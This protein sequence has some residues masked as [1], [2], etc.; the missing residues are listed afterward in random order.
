MK[1]L[2][3]FLMVGLAFTVLQ[4]AGVEAQEQFVDPDCPPG[5]P[6]GTT[7]MPGGEQVGAPMCDSNPACDPSDPAAN[8][9]AGMCDPNPACVMDD[10]NAIPC[11]GPMDGPPGGQHDGPPGSHDGPPIDPRSGQPF[12]KADEDKFQKYA[13][14]CESTQGLISQGSK[15]ELIA[16]GFTAIMVDDLCKNGPQDA[17]PA[18]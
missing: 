15:D 3:Y 16:E 11:C 13:D 7:C 12:T 9:C 18:P 4:V 14:E 10:P 8:C 17:P 5:T 6:A 2:S 1:K